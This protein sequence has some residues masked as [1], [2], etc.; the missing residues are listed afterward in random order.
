MKKVS[1]IDIGGTGSNIEMKRWLVQATLAGSL[2]VSLGLNAASLPKAP[3]F[4]ERD[5][6]MAKVQYIKAFAWP[7]R[8]KR[9]MDSLFSEKPRVVQAPTKANAKGKESTAKE[10][11]SA[12]Q[13][14]TESTPET[15]EKSGE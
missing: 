4:S 7:A 15:N 3:A 13:V 1:Q 14:P 10:A 2:I 8:A 12:E 6:A 5:F 11:P 9:P